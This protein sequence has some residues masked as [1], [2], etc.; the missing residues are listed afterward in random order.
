MTRVRAG[1]VTVGTKN[2]PMNAVGSFEV[3][4]D[5]SLSGFGSVMNLT[6]SGTVFLNEREP[7]KAFANIF[8]VNKNYV[9]KGGVLVFNATLSSDNDSRQ[10]QLRIKGN[11]TGTILIR[12]NHL[13]GEGAPAEKAITLITIEGKSEAHFA[14]E[15]PVSAG[16]Y[17]YELFSS[18]GLKNWY[19][20]TKDKIVRS[21][22]GSYI[23]AILASVQ[24][25][26]R[27]HDR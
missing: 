1:G 7:R 22:A 10:D 11:A 12:V 21:E 26:M 2:A 16:A 4:K 19:L 24:M 15:R 20:S 25:S 18:E 23:G 13:G 9:G 27:L 3:E 5:G 14:L 6:N 17:N 8:T